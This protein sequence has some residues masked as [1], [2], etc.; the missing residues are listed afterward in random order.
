MFLNVIVI[1]ILI[2]F[3]IGFL[4]YKRYKLEDVVFRFGVVYDLN[5][6]YCG[7]YDVKVFVN[8]WV[9][10]I[11][12]L[13]FKNIFIFEDLGNFIFNDLYVKMYGYEVLIIVLNN[14]GLKK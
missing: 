12:E 9:N 4:N 11:F 6:V 1:D 8:V 13:N 3:R 2:V 5:V 10:I 14:K 7:D